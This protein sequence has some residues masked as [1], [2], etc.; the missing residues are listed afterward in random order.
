MDKINKKTAH[1]VIY[2]IKMEYNKIYNLT[3]KSIKVKVK[4]GKKEIKIKRIEKEEINRIHHRM[5]SQI[6]QAQV[7]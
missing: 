4:K 1:Y 2:L 3:T 5:E 7:L 6:I